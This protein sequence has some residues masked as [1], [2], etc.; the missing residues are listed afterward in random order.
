MAEVCLDHVW[1]EYRLGAGGIRELFSQ[2]KGGFRKQEAT[3]ANT[4][5]AL[6]DVSF[7]VG[8]GE[9]IGIVGHNGAGKSTILKMLAGITAPTR[10]EVRVSGRLSSLIELGAGFHGDLTGRENIFLN[11]SILGLS[12]K[13]LSDKFDDIVAFAELARFIDT[14]LKRYSSGMQARLA[15]SVAVHLDP[16]VLL[17]DEV[18]SVGDYAF[19][20]KSFDR[21]L[22]FKRR[23]T[24]IVFVSH[25]LG[26]VSLLCDR[27]IWLQHGKVVQFGKAAEVIEAYLQDYDRKAAEAVRQRDPEGLVGT[28][29]LAVERAE[30][31]DAA[32]HP[33][34]TFPFRSPMRIRLHYH[35]S[36]PI[37]RPFFALGISGDQGPLFM[38]NMVMDDCR[39]TCLDGRG[40]FDCYFE[41]L[42]L[43]PGTYQVSCTVLRDFRARYQD[44]H[45]V[46]A[47]RVDSPLSEYGFHGEW[48]IAISR[49]SCP[50]YVPYR[51]EFDPMHEAGHKNGHALVGAAGTAGKEG[52]K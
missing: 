28:G 26:S 4:L 45:T 44:A 10:G 7:D 35:A 34:D 42:P 29:E 6:H 38:A 3:A 36:R 37:E 2:L 16:E 47:F 1:K 19:Q 30:F 5:I 14:P 41:E 17:V 39:P 27:V 24:H 13:E 11:G 49:D 43:L 32:G 31:L 22:D 50:V 9:T 18:L 33:C 48:A 8:S 52:A 40:Y 46:G 15:F 25:N 20:R 21:I 12:R 51:W 23:G